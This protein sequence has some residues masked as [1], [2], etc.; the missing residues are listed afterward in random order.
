M[1][2]SDAR[3]EVQRVLRET[4]DLP[5][6]QRLLLV[7]YAV[8]DTDEIGTVHATGAELAAEASMSPQLLSRVRR[9]LISGGWLEESGE[10]LG[11]MRFYR[12]TD[13]TTGRQT[14]TP[15]RPTA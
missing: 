4:G 15:L 1:N 2:T 3:A 6:L 10:R 5:P 12:R 8:S 11:N 14:V 7:L 13:K 9:E